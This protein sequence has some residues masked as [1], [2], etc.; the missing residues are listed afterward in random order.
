MP[1]GAKQVLRVARMVWCVKNFNN[2]CNKP[3]IQC[4]PQSQIV[5]MTIRF[6]K[7]QMEPLMGLE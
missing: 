3:D 4:Q 1:K 2:I 5:Y 7:Q 6:L